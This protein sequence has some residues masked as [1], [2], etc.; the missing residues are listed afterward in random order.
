MDQAPYLVVAVVALASG[1]ISAMVSNWLAGRAQ[2]SE[3]MREARLRVYPSVWLLT[4]LFSKYP[5][6]KATVGQT[7]QL[8]IEL[9]SWYFE[10][11]GLYL[12]EH[13]RARYGDVQELLEAYTDK[14]DQ[15]KADAEDFPDDGPYRFMQDACST[16]RTAL[17]EDLES[18]RQRSLVTSL[19]RSRQHRKEKR[20]GKER[21]AKVT[22]RQGT[23]IHEVRIHG[24]SMPSLTDSLK[25]IESR[26]SSGSVN[27]TAEPEAPPGPGA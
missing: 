24:A 11:G 6:T 10:V 22:G 27:E 8:H 13:S 7:K 5:W 15:T 17:T 23:P 12:S 3:A 1:L 2:V 19:W 16:F 14:T 4:D 21:E 18:R 9:R 20:E 26:R 25:L